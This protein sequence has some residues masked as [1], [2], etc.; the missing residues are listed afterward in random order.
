M[1]DTPRPASVYSVAMD[2][3]MA[4]G[5]RTSL[6]EWPDS[7]AVDPSGARFAII[8]VGDAAAEIA[9]GWAS[10]LDRPVWTFHADRAA[11]AFDALDAQVRQARVGW[12]LMLAGPEADVLA[13]RSRAI[14]G[15]AVDEEIRCQV[16]SRERVVVHCAHC[17]AE[18]AVTASAGERATCSGCGQPLHI[19]SHVSRYRGAY[20]G[21]RADV[22]AFR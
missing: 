2:E 6:P 5:A 8:G 19:Y 15:G 17:A 3:R 14:S 7:V 18:T 12:R 11:D 9:R 21:F 4:V 20:L 13:L 10:S 22:E 16:T 1:V